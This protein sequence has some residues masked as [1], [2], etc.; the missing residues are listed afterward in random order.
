MKKLVLFLSFFVCG[1]SVAPFLVGPIITGVVMWKQGEAKKYYNEDL[2]IIYRATKNSLKELD[3]QI[4]SDEKTK[5]GYF[6]TA[7]EKNKFKIPILILTS[8]SSIF[9]KKIIMPHQFQNS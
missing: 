4:H 9:I 1:C 8:F 3:H 6:L 7:G 2:I 5:D